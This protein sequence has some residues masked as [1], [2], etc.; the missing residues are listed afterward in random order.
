[1]W[2]TQMHLGAPHRF[3][4]DFR[5]RGA[6]RVGFPE[7][8]C[9]TFRV[10]ENPTAAPTVASPRIP[11]VQSRGAPRS[12]A[13][14]LGARGIVNVGSE[15]TLTF[16]GHGRCKG[17]RQRASPIR[18]MWVRCGFDVGSMWVRCGFDVGSMWVRCGYDVGTMWVRCGYSVEGGGGVRSEVDE[19]G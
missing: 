17:P 16:G 1:M 2:C 10:A 18:S 9:Y 14:P 19:G 15:P 13:P 8:L 11:S 6:R 12:G 4:G 3:F 7:K 5:C